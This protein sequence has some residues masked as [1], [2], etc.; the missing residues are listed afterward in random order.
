MRQ[1]ISIRFWLVGLVFLL[2]AT[3]TACI[4]VFRIWP[5]TNKQASSDTKPSHA[6]YLIGEKEREDETFIGLALSG[7]GS[8]AAIFSTAVM[9]ELKRLGILDRVDFISSVSGG[10]LPA[11][12]YALE[13]YHYQGIKFDGPEVLEKM[14]FDF[15]ARWV[16]RWLLPQNIVRYWF[17]DFTRSDIMVQVFDN[18]LFHDATYADLNPN[19]PKLLINATDAGKFDKFTFTD[20]SFAQI[21]SNLQLYSVARA[22]NVSSAFPGAFQSVTLQDFQPNTS[23]PNKS[24]YLHLYDG[25]PADNL[26]LTT[27]VDV[28][29]RAICE[30]AISEQVTTQQVISQKTISAQTVCQAGKTPIPITTLFPKGCVLI[31]VDA[32]PRGRNRDLEH[33]HVRRFADY[34]FDRNFL[35]ATDVMLLSIRREVLEN[36]GIKKE[37]I[38]KTMV[39]TYPLPGNNGSCQIWHLALRHLPEGDPLGDRVTDIETSFGIEVGEQED[40]IQAAKRLVNEQKADPKIGFLFS[41]LKSK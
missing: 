29:L 26:G 16:G 13:D 10:S 11:A 17:A 40:L 35:N 6:N 12:Y 3:S 1:L 33:A 38:D 14:G 18:N 34:V 36:V 8:R 37:D 41:D 5:Y 22:V 2:L 27:L 24:K 21:G 31:A 25:G 19:R 23:Q 32:T 20:E 30:G 7:G 39:A 4:A 15:Q 28:Q 9:L